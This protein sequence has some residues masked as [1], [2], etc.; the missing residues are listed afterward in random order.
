V[1]R[2][3]I[4]TRSAFHLLLS[5]DLVE[6]LYHYSEGDRGIEIA[7]RNSETKPLHKQTEAD[8]QKE[9]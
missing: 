5:R 8:C 2:A 6:T 7:P 4:A 1:V 9:A 3:R